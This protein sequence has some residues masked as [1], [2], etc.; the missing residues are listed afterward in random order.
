M[1][2]RGLILSISFCIILSAFAL[3]GHSFYTMIFVDNTKPG[4]KTAE[5]YIPTDSN[6]EDVL[7]L[8]KNKDIIK[9]ISSLEWV[10]NKKKYHKLVKSGR[11]IL[12]E[13]MSNNGIVNL[14]RSGSQTSVNFTFNNTRTLS[15]FCD[16]VAS[17]LEFDSESLMIYLKSKETQEKYGFNSQNIISL[18][19]P[20]T[21]KLYWDISIDSFVEKMYKE[22]RKF[23]NDQRM[24]TAKQLGLSFQEVSTLAS[25]VD[26]E[27]NYNPE[28]AIVA[29]VYINRLK[30]GR[31]LEADPTLKFAVGDFSIKRVLNKHKEVDSPYNT[32][33]NAGL[34]PGPIRQAS[35]KG[36]DAVLN[37]KKHSYYYFCASPKFDGTHIFAR[38]LREHNNNAIKYRRELNKKGIRK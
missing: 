23:W 24:K 8:L 37:Y 15:E 4:F 33:K 35:V 3:I 16:K 6:M 34:P 9:D 21:Y 28:K 2:K 31:R 20:N 10:M 7:I 13:K 22:Y 17:Q 1:K 30:K 36:I 26:A 12:K 25:I 38:S 27:T 14:L 11:Y 18:F 29:G 32:Y 5:I 19:I